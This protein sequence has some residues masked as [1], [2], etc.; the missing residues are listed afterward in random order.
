MRVIRVFPRRTSQ[1]PTEE[2]RHFQRTWSRPAAMFALMGK[3]G[4]KQ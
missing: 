2:W 4:K 3:E 1:T